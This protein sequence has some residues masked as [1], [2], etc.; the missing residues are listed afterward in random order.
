[1]LGAWCWVHGRRASGDLSWKWVK[2]PPLPAHLGGLPSCHG[3][4]PVFGR[5]GSLC[6]HG[7]VEELMGWNFSQGWLWDSNSGIENLETKGVLATRGHTKAS[8]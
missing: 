8:L 1:M 5:V 4:S 7:D 6:Y 3:A 2:V